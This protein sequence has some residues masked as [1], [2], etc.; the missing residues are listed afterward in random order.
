MQLIHVQPSYYAAIKSLYALPY[1]NPYRKAFDIKLDVLI[2][3]LKYL[4]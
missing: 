2:I 3:I 4:T 1:T